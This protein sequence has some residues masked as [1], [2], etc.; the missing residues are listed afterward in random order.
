MKHSQI[1][2][3]L[4]ILAFFLASCGEEP[5]ADSLSLDKTQ[6][7]FNASPGDQTIQVSAN[8][9]W[10]VAV[11]EGSTWLSVSPRQGEG[12][13]TLTLSAQANTGADRTAALK[14]YSADKEVRITVLQKE[15]EIL[16]WSLSQVR[17]LYKGTDVKVT[18]KVVVKA[19]VI[20]NYLHTDNG[21]LNNYTSMKA[22][23]VS[24]G[25]AGIQLYCAENNTTFKPGD[26]VEIQLMG[27][28]L[29]VYN[30]GPLQVN[31]IPLS[32]IT[33]TGT[34]TVLAKEITAAQLVTGAFESMYVAIPGVQVTD[35]DL[36]KTFVVASAHTSIG[37]TAQTKENFDIFSS[38]YSSFKD[39]VVPSGSGVLKGI[40][41]VYDGRYQISFAKV[42][43]WEG[44]TGERFYTSPTFSLFTTEK[45][46]PG[47]AGQFTVSLAAN[48]DWT[49]SSSDP[50]GFAVS[51]SSGKGSSP[52]T[53]VYTQNPSLTVPRT[54]DIV[55]S[56]DDPSIT[57]QTLTL[58]ITQSPF[59]A[60]VSDP[61]MSWMELPEV[62][63]KDDFAYISHMTTL[64]GK[65]VRNYSFWYDTQNRL[66][67]WVAYPL[68][69]SIMGSGSRTDAW[70][71]NPKVPKR[72]QPALFSSF[73]GSVYDRGH[74][75][76][77]ADRL[78]SQE[79][80]ASTF[81]FTNI[82]AQNSSLNQN[83]WANLE[84]Y[85]R[86]WAQ[87][88]DTLY[89]VTG[90]M[91]QIAENNTVNYANDNEGNKV[92]VP[93]MYYKV[94]LKYKAG[95]T[96]NEGYSSI[97][98]CYENRAYNAEYPLASDAKSVKEMEALT[99]YN[100]FHNLPD[101]LEEAVEKSCVP[102]DWGLN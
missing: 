69:Q 48:V 88:C 4:V 25:E 47:E 28:T 95:Q 31:G 82:T 21:G 74:Q 102:K 6:V 41:S 37:M 99:G 17:A 23:V 22:I 45:E 43:D 55:F 94:L 58:H 89:V 40:A 1:T 62:Q 101:A 80:N 71:Y 27:Q 92:A 50:E 15:Q 18:E 30:K 53:V 51:P 33:K 79:V 77:S 44:L 49:V 29:S 34:E 93:V 3:V 7:T 70:A 38:K 42:S 16:N 91:I 59:E 60:L 68:Y 83:L 81:Y 65:S 54:A 90:A 98:F 100:F 52:L 85:V 2:G 19:T 78:Y 46:V 72:H 32:N 24:D 63:K 84:I 5:V 14:V 35:E 76:P 11:T 8:C 39:V 36:N 64:K 75:L 12:N 9:P 86:N 57:T 66:A 67:L 96:E 73:G 20:S 56:T 26:Q 61:V 13:G 10:S 87:S 97:G